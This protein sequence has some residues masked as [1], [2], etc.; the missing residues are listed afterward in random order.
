ML[1]NIKWILTPTKLSSDI[2][3]FEG[4][5]GEFLGNHVMTFHLLCSSNSLMDESLDFNSSSTP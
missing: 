1:H 3:K 4:K 2:A 5:Y